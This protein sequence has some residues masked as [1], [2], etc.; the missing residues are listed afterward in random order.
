MRV[1][2]YIAKNQAFTLEEFRHEFGE[3]RTA[4]NLL[5]RSITAGRA[6]RVM[7]SIFVSRTGRFEGV[8]PNGYVIAQAIDRSAVFSYHS[9]LTLHGVA[10]NESSRIQFYSKNR[11]VN[12]TYAGLEFISYPY[13]QEL[14]TIVRASSALADA[15]TAITS[16]EQTIIDC[17]DHV[18]RSGGSEEVVRSLSSF[19]YI[20][21]EI[22]TKLLK[23]RTKATIARTGW[24]LRRNQKVWEVPDETIDSIRQQI[25]KG[26]YRFSP[27]QGKGMSDNW[28]TEWHLLLPAPKEEIASWL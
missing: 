12:L 1:G 19:P 25:S 18:G 5:V 26:P 27:T 10:H 14:A 9:A 21:T 20:D 15:S 8:A 24:L 22:L 23:G 13:P 28:D 3:S 17:L 7:R 11:S 6:D 2:E 4:Y 16:I